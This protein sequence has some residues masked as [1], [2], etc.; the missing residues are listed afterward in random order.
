MLNYT[1]LNL[2]LFAGEGAGTGGGEGAAT[3]GNEAVDAGQ[4]RL[5]ELGVPA[6][7]I[8]KRS[9]NS[10]SVLPDNAVTSKP[11]K[12]EQQNVQVDAADADTEETKST[13][14]NSENGQ[15]RMTWDEIMNDPEY[16]KQ[17]QSVV[18]ARLK[19]A[20]SAEDTLSKLMPAVEMLAQRYGLDT[21]NMDYDAFAKAVE[22]DDSLYE[23]KALELGVS[24]DIAKRLEREK[25]LTAEKNRTIEQQKFRQHI[26]NLES[27]AE[28]MK[29]VF[30]TFDLRKELQNPYFARMTAPNVGISE[31]DAYYA[32]HRA[33]IQAAA[34]KVTA[35][36]TA[37]N[38]SNA[39]QAGSRRPVENGTSGQAASVTKFDYR[40]A[41]QEQR[42]ALKKRIREAAA[43]GEKLYPGR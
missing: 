41:S 20:K 33:E 30:P 28:A 43:N 26:E 24:V 22:D 10:A 31:E 40:N 25:Q 18:Q 34:M 2:Q 7:K 29:A 6:D 13:E 39:I 15:K 3:G 27:Q 4:S 11:Q 5:L 17:M 8:R 23:E 12:N 37:E 16:N 9:K 21:E 1:W 14:D 19:S 36:K 32:V 42:D 38:L 35:Q